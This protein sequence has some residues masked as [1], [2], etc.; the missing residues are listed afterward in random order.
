MMQEPK[1]ECWEYEVFTRAQ[2]GDILTHIG[3]VEAESDELA[4]VYASRIYDEVNWVEM[5][6]VK[7][8]DMVCV[9]LPMTQQTAEEVTANV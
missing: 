3:T 6:V 7:R 8:K 9:R 2:R 1:R 5:Y 4:K